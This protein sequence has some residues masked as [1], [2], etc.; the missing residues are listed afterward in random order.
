MRCKASCEFTFQCHFKSDFA[1]CTLLM[2]I[3]FPQ[4]KNQLKGVSMKVTFK[5][6]LKNI[7]TL[8]ERF[9]KLRNSRLNM[10]QFGNRFYDTYA[11]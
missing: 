8:S 7:C 5:K 6:W 4:Y 11:S 3:C 9:L 2:S 10:N 1:V